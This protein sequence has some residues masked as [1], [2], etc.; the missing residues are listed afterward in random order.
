MV[1]KYGL[2]ASACNTGT[3]SISIWR[4]AAEA[5]HKG[6]WHVGTRP[7]DDGCDDPVT[8]P[9]PIKAHHGRVSY[10]NIKEIFGA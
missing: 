6:R 8:I 7:C 10:Y 1:G 3:E 5:Y 9:P 2:A 4:Y